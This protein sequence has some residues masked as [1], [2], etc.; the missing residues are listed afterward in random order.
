MTRQTRAFSAAVGFSRA[1]AADYVNISGAT[2]SAAVDAPRFTYDPVS[3]ARK[4]L[5]IEGV[6]QNPAPDLAITPP[7]AAPPAWLSLPC[8][9]VI[10]HHWFDAA[11]VERWDA[12]FTD[13]P[14]S[15]W[16]GLLRKRGAHAERHSLAF[17]PVD[18]DD[19][20]GDPP[21]LIRDGDDLFWIKD[22]AQAWA[23]Q[24]ALLTTDTDEHLLT[25]P[26]ER[27]IVGALV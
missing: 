1:C 5:M 2:V 17:D 27:V 13:D 20:T 4:G 18:V 21:G 24:T 14:L 22:P 11:D 25:A 8:H 16:N 26:G 12:H 10:L 9:R 19:V 3:H 15:T 23:V 6:G 7:S